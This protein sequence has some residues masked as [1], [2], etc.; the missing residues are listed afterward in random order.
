MTGLP[1]DVWAMMIFSVLVFFGI[2]IWMLLYT[3][4]EEERKMDILRS[5][6]AIDTHSPTALHE[7]RAWIEAHPNDP[8]VDDARATY[9][10]CVEALQSTNRHFY[11]WSDE[12]I[13]RLEER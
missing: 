4:R 3:L 7:L 13:V 8:D 11:D 2:S 9:R 12:E 1:F 6:G 5:E 10:E